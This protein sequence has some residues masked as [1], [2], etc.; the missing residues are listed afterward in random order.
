MPASAPAALLP[1]VCVRPVLPRSG[2]CDG[3][4]TVNRVVDRVVFLHVVIVI[5]WH[6]DL[7][8]RKKSPCLQGHT[9]WELCKFS[10]NRKQDQSGSVVIYLYAILF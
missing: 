9:K 2:V 4:H 10:A 5:V 1:L 8:Q 6:R 7:Q 3:N